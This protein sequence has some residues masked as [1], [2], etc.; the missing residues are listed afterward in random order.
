MA[1]D[2]ERWLRD[3]GGPPPK[4]EDAKRLLT[5]QWIR[6]ALNGSSVL[7]S[8]P[9]RLLAKGSFV[10]RTNTTLES[11]VDLVVEYGTDGP[12]YFHLGGDAALYQP[13]QLGLQPLTIGVQP[14]QLKHLVYDALAS[15]FGPDEVAWGET[16]IKV[17]ARRMTIRADVVPAVAYRYYF[18]FDSDGQALWLAG[19]R[20]WTDT[21]VM[22]TNWP[23]QHYHEGVAKNDATRRRFKQM[24][25]ALKRLE[26]ELHDAGHIQEVPSFLS[27]CLVYNVPDEHFGHDLH[28]DD[29]RNLLWTI[30]QA[31]NDTASCAHW[32]EVSRMKPLF[33]AGQR[34]TSQQ[35]NGLAVAAWDW[36]GL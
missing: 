15:A 18:G 11:D 17:R 16:A 14:Q 4:K 6:S 34:W 22:I 36:M 35:A 19:H 30:A 29:M 9:L 10:N 26:N 25:R 31:T 2:W 32:V 13:W 21:G 20:L 33:G 8:L 3:S 7:A 23:D 28:L 24:V 1:R 5:E 12:F 27:E